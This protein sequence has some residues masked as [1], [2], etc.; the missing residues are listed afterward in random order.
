MNAGAQ[1]AMT[2]G[3]ASMVNIP[4]FLQRA[5]AEGTIGISG[6]KLLF[7]FL[8][9]GNDGINNIVPIQDPSYAAFRQA[10]GLPKDPAVFYDATPGQCDNPGALQPYAI[11]LGNGFAA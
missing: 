10:I 9:G 3:L 6:K 4:L 5:L 2:E 11:R 8:R 7:I 1:A